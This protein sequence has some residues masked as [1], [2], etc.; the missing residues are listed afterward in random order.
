MD[1]NNRRNV[2][3]FGAA[4]AVIG[5][6]MAVAVAGLWFAPGQIRREEGSAGL[7]PEDRGGV[8]Y[9]DVRD[10]KKVV[11]Y[12]DAKA[13]C[14]VNA[15]QLTEFKQPGS[16]PRVVVYDI[17]EEEDYTEGP[18]KIRRLSYD[19]WEYGRQYQAILAEYVKMY[20]EAAAFPENQSCR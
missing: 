13:R 20:P 15:V 19:G 9:V 7:F 10:P 18:L 16:Y 5:L 14:V 11:Y 8:I 6:A 4:V 2:I 12:W 3:F 1:K 17:Q